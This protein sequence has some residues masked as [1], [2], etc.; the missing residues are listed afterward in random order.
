[1]FRTNLF[2]FLSLP[3]HITNKVNE[4]TEAQPTDIDDANK[5]NTSPQVRGRS[6][7]HQG[8]ESNSTSEINTTSNTADTSD[9]CDADHFEDAT[10]ERNTDKSS[11]DS[12]SAINKS[13]NTEDA[14]RTDKVF[15]SLV[16]CATFTSA[17]S[18]PKQTPVHSQESSQT[19]PSD[20]KTNV[21]AR[22]KDDMAPPHYEG[23]FASQ[24]LHKRDKPR[25]NSGAKFGM[26]EDGFGVRNIDFG[27]RNSRLEVRHS[28]DLAQ[29]D[30]D[31]AFAGHN[32]WREATMRSAPPPPFSGAHFQQ[33]D[34]LKRRAAV[35]DLDSDDTSKRSRFEV[36]PTAHQSRTAGEMR[37]P[38]RPPVRRETR[39][40]VDLSDDSRNV[41]TMRGS[42][43][44]PARREYQEVV[45]LSDDEH[46]ASDA[47]G[48]RTA[49]DY[50]A[51]HQSQ[52][53]GGVQ[54]SSQKGLSLMPNSQGRRR[55][56]VDQDFSDT[57]M[58]SG[59]T[60]QRRNWNDTYRN[61]E[62]RPA[63]ASHRN[64]RILIMSPQ[65]HVYEPDLR[66]S[67]QRQ[68]ERV[69]RE[70]AVH[71]Q[72]DNTY[73]SV[74]GAD[75]TNRM[76]WA[77]TPH[78]GQKTNSTGI[79]RVPSKHLD[80]VS[81]T[82]PSLLHQPQADRSSLG[83]SI[84][85]RPQAAPKPHYQSV[86]PFTEEDDSEN[87]DSSTRSL[88][89]GEGAAREHSPDIHMVN[90]NNAPLP[91][92]QS[93]EA[94]AISHDCDD[95]SNEDNNSSLFMPQPTMDPRRRKDRQPRRVTATNGNGHSESDRSGQ[96][97]D[98]TLETPS[99][100]TLSTES[101]YDRMIR[102]RK[103]Q[104]DAE[105]ANREKTRISTEMQDPRRAVGTIQQSA[106]D[107]PATEPMRGSPMD[108][109]VQH[110]MPVANM[111][112]ASLPRAPMPQATSSGFQVSNDSNS[113]NNGGVSA[114]FA[115]SYLSPAESHGGG[116]HRPYH[117]REQERLQRIKKVQEEMDKM[118]EK[119]Q[120]T[121]D[122]NFMAGISGF[123]YKLEKHEKDEVARQAEVKRRKTRL[124]FREQDPLESP[125]LV[126]AVPAI[127]PILEDDL[128]DA[129]TSGVDFTDS[130]VRQFVIKNTDRKVH[131]W[132]QKGLNWSEVTALVKRSTGK[133]RVSTQHIRLRQDLTVR[134]LAMIA[135]DKELEELMPERPDPFADSGDERQRLVSGWKPH[136]YG[137]D[138]IVDG[139]SLVAPKIKIEEDAPASQAL[140]TAALHEKEKL[141]E[142]EERG[143]LKAALEQEKQKVE[144][145]RREKEQLE[146]EMRAREEADRARR[147]AEL[148]AERVKA[149]EENN[150]RLHQ[151]S[152]ARRP[153][154]WRAHSTGFSFAKP[155]RDEYGSEE[156]E[157]DRR[158]S[159]KKNKK[160]STPKK[161]SKKTREEGSGDET[162]PED[163]TPA[164]EP[165][166]KKG[167]KKTDTVELRPDG[168]PKTA[169]KSLPQKYIQAYLKHAEKAL[170]EVEDEEDELSPEE[171]LDGD[172]SYNVYYVKRKQWLRSEETD[173]EEPPDT[174]EFKCFETT[175]LKEANMEASKE[176]F[177]PQGEAG[178]VFDHGDAFNG[179]EFSRHDG[180][181]AQLLTVPTGY[182]RVW[183]EK[184]VCSAFQGQLPKFEPHS[185]IDRK[186]W[187]VKKQTW[188]LQSTDGEDQGK[189]LLAEESGD[190][191]TTFDLA[192]REAS[193]KFLD[194]TFVPTARRLEDVLVQRSQAQQETMEKLEELEEQGEL[195]LQ[196]DTLKNGQL[197]KVWV[198]AGKLKGPRN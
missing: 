128:I 175:D 18:A 189:T 32:S 91:P 70:T 126:D 97:S 111:G 185:F 156:S 30:D 50:T 180:M 127:P 38:S 143:R 46:D 188:V 119:P 114:D 59:F 163:A 103:I 172:L 118:I 55:N 12:P 102:L 14:N 79:G 139:G 120:V 101:E 184:E 86:A 158:S 45:M 48:H 47:W 183:V 178:I 77:A 179:I 31:D 134:K 98:P 10:E 170:A 124:G 107:A 151:A 80:S 4:T 104:A 192:N 78:A 1:M 147:K 169:G 57:A 153:V 8:G 166:P 19:A 113:H 7:I 39:E 110:R 130:E 88:F 21:G 81:S 141:K 73:D 181:V 3:G 116:A 63:P 22:H 40:V 13:T 145:E 35:I 11:S 167:K 112:Q 23:N 96:P 34:T 99:V 92:E 190:I 6:D 162:D 149:T 61:N 27:A 174:I 136:T 121:R 2:S 87:D 60:G 129:V 25:P 196:E 64:N 9:L 197:V 159:K 5:V 152:L 75:Q 69:H 71:Y 117:L 115:N 44:P 194:A 148:E 53:K 135:A 191:C 74:H 26:G 123:D 24:R 42:S 33:Q 168:F 65:L 160:K 66:E 93:H 56:N 138:Q 76:S 193:T 140:H 144:K 43:R 106:P 173:D 177:R 161:A 68:F 51:A 131:G 105:A 157:K 72:P 125:A 95:E 186:V 28:S 29:E 150:K 109:R 58:A 100:M 84:F 85:D 90:S 94:T 37:R 89:V 83:T 195:F 146:E 52:S 41:N 36:K 137:L 171:I 142:Q 182:V 62:A 164:T 133:E 82:G 155:R 54:P 132:R 176:I 122:E 154:A 108:P 16:T 17:E 165:N 15:G 67:K 20:Y 49:P 198:E 187:V